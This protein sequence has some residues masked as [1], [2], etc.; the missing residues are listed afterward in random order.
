MLIRPKG[1]SLSAYYAALEIH[2]IYCVQKVTQSKKE[3]NNIQKRIHTVENSMFMY[4]VLCDIKLVMNS[5]SETGSHF[6]ALATW[7]LIFR[8]G[9]HR[10]HR[11]PLAFASPM[12]QLKLCTITPSLHVFLCMYLQNDIISI[13]KTVWRTYSLKIISL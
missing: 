3:R 13:L 1:R 2:D 9:W 11:A 10:T 8:Q 12:L 5:F 6:V 4:S 7:N